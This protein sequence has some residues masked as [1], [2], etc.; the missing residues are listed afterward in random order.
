MPRFAQLVGKRLLF[1]IP[2]LFAVSVIVFFLLRLLPGDPSYMLAGPYASPQRIQEYVAASVSISRSCR[3]TSTISAVS[4]WETSGRRCVPPSRCSPNRAATARNPGTGRRCR[5]AFGR[6]WHSAR[7]RG[8]CQERRGAGARPIFL[9]NA[10]RFVAGL[11]VGLLLIL[12][13]F[14][15]LG[16]APA[17]V[18]Q[19]EFA[20]STP[21]HVTGAYVVDLLLTGNWQPSG[22]P[23]ATLRCRSPP[24]CSSTCRSF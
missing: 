17:P 16:W 14:Y 20:V 13:F 22:R 24:S 4:R 11:L 6:H 15:F 23:S 5:L 19:L 9:R 1:V 2:Q 10:S 12:V 21:D 8:G 3:N 18:G 7:G